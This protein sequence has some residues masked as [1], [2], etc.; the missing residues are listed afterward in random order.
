MFSCKASKSK[1]H[2][3]TA[4]DIILGSILAP[5]VCSLFLS[6]GF[7]TEKRSQIKPNDMY[8]QE[9]LT[10]KSRGKSVFFWRQL[11]VRVTCLS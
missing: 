4:N 5:L 8:D 1:L 10:A 3:I 7:Y 6:A 11:E 2:S 9:A